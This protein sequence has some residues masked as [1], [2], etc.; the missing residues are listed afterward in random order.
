LAQARRARGDE[1][2]QARRRSI[3]RV[4]IAKL[5]R[6]PFQRLTMAEL[7]RGAG[8]AKGTTYLYF[9]SKEEL[10]LAALQEMLGAWFDDVDA[11]LERAAGRLAPAQVVRLVVDSVVRREDLA[12]LLTVLHTSLE[13]NVPVA[14]AL[15]F[16]QAVQAHLLRSGALLE[17]AL[18]FLG[19]GG[20]SRLLLRV[21]AL[22]IGLWQMAEPAP[23][24]RQVLEMPGM[25][26]FRIDFGAE[27]RGALGALLGGLETEAG[28]G[29][30]A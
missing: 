28:K 6:K 13:H 4:A 30:R 1:G 17:R 7:A 25:D 8:L 15:A 21:N 11:R 2:K 23:V 16:K 20:G 9:R 18:P 3:V 10:F 5:Q 14:A 26:V 19:A 12:R 27:L 24:M 22:T 29:R